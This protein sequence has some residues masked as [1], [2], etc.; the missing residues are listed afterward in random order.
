MSLRSLFE[1]LEPPRLEELVS[2]ELEE[3][4]TLKERKGILCTF[5]RG[6]GNHQTRMDLLK[7]FTTVL[8][9]IYWLRILLT[10][11]T[12]CTERVKWHPHNGEA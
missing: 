8:F 1:N 11:S 6:T 3:E 7:N 9:L 10:N 4:I 5:S 12:L 2:S